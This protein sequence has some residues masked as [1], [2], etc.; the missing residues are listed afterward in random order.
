MFKNWNEKN[1]MY[2]RLFH[3]VDQQKDPELRARMSKAF[4][5]IRRVNRE[6]ETLAAE[7]G[8]QL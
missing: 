5:E 3:I 2:N 8:E 1:R 6:F 4:A 7:A